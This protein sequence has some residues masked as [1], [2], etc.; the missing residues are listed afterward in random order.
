MW[1][2]LLA[3]LLIVITW[4]AL[5]PAPPRT[6]DTGWD[7]SNHALA[8]AAL[9]FAAVWAMWPRPRQWLVL[10]AAL[11]VYG[12]AIEVAQ[13]FVPSRSA[14]W[15]DVLAD[16]LGIAIGLAAAW[17]VAGTAARRP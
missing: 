5:S 17:P 14:D 12:G 2:A 9:A 6:V 15:L 1:R 11:L 7:K 4:L 3:L 10:V 16:G 8:F 13:G